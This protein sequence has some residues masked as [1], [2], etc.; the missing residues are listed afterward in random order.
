M[1]QNLCRAHQ[2]AVTSPSY[3]PFG[4][5]E[6]EAATAEIDLPP[7]TRKQQAGT[8]ATDLRLGAWP[9]A[10]LCILCKSESTCR[11]SPLEVAEKGLQG[12]YFVHPER[13]APKPQCTRTQLR[14]KADTAKQEDAINE[15]DAQTFMQTVIMSFVRGMTFPSMTFLSTSQCRCSLP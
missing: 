9:M 5:Q 11:H 10:R 1:Y 14:P 8:A 12:P 7:S 3:S 2:S 13:S 6:Q 15:V 4:A